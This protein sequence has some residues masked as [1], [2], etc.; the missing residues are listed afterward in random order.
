MKRIELN[1]VIETIPNHCFASCTNLNEVII[2]K[3]VKSIYRNAFDNCMRL[4]EIDIPEN[5]KTIGESAFSRC[6][7][8]VKVI[9]NTDTK[10]IDYRLFN[11]CTKIRI[12]SSP[13]M[14]K[15]SNISLEEDSSVVC[16]YGV[17]RI[18]NVLTTSQARLIEEDGY[19]FLETINDNK[20]YLIGCL[21]EESEIVLPI[22]INKKSYEIARYAFNYIK[23]INKI[24]IESGVTRICPYAFAN[25]TNLEEVR[26]AP[27]VTS[28][29]EFI[30]ANCHKIK[31]LYYSDT[32]A[33]WKNI[34]F[35]DKWNY[36]DNY[37][38]AVRVIHTINGDL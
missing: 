30:F 28:I 3:K 20:Y 35:M 6:F 11:F 14:E 32:K 29:G 9:I 31:N 36:R 19:L 10:D 1:D 24:T 13:F 25:C 5:V 16:N 23:N 33:K 4:Y 2:G 34:E 15:N 17:F 26:I 37:N 8:L 38:S 27:S 7:N 18:F 12:F 21:K 22:S